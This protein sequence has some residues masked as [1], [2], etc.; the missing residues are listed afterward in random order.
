[1]VATTSLP[2]IPTQSPDEHNSCGQFTT[3]ET[4]AIMPCV[5]ALIGPTEAGTCQYW[6]AKQVRNSTTNT[7]TPART[8]HCAVAV[9]TP[10]PPP[11]SP[12][13]R[14]LGFRFLSPPFD[15]TTTT[16]RMLDVMHTPAATR[17]CKKYCATSTPRPHTHARSPPY[18]SPALTP[19][20]ITGWGFAVSLDLQV[21]E[22]LQTLPQAQP[23]PHPNPQPAG[24]SSTVQSVGI[25]K[26]NLA[27]PAGGTGRILT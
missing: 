3:K 13:A 7:P 26:R 6:A 1:V 14:S 24:T 20:P 19:L 11:P 8:C 9:P 17:S 4:C 2:T 15:P 23:T 25:Y 12:L 27:F 10:S 18:L 21:T 22:Q 16:T 5:W